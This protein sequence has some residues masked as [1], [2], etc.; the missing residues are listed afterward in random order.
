MAMDK[1][2]AN[3]VLF[4][5][6][7]SFL[8]GRKREARFRGERRKRAFEERRGP[9][10]LSESDFWA[11]VGGCGYFSS[12]QKE[13]GSWDSIRPPTG[14]LGLFSF[15]HI[16]GGPKNFLKNIIYQSWLQGEIL[17]TIQVPLS[18]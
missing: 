13:T 6:V 11:E 4:I 15:I 17:I 12:H 5:R 10:Q 7:I 9:L 3:H 1:A 2:C 14:V 16:T 18:L 8:S